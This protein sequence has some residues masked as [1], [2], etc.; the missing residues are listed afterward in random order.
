MALRRSL[1]GDPEGSVG[2][3]A[4][5]A[6][7]ARAAG[8]SPAA[9][10]VGAAVILVSG[11]SGTRATCTAVYQVTLFRSLQP[12]AAAAPQFNSHARPSPRLTRQA[13]SDADRRTE[14][15]LK[16]FAKGPAS[17]L[18]AAA[19]GEALRQ[20]VGHGGGADVQ[21][22][23]AKVA[24]VALAANA[25]NITRW[26]AVVLHDALSDADR[27]TEL[28][29]KLFARGPASDLAADAF[30]VALRQFVGH[31]GGADIQSAA[32]KVAAVALAANA[33]SMT[34]GFAAVLHDAL[35]D[36]DRRTE[37]GLKLVAKGAAD[38]QAL[39]TCSL[40]ERGDQKWHCKHAKCSALSWPSKFAALQHIELRCADHHETKRGHGWGALI[41]F[42]R[43]CFPE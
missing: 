4:L 7:A 32:A 30:G 41:P 10:A 11:S 39:A 29:L 17:D 18:A 9:A 33:G 8:I 37:L 20:F 38:K 25:G 28:G 16:L 15:G 22:A 42:Q 12:A 27:R 3:S 43:T 13:L 40:L 19:F 35:S 1:G 14:L 31:G 36:A 6:S 5:L 24:A 26:F 34:G 23:A 2:V 21:S